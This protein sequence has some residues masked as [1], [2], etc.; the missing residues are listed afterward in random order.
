MPVKAFQQAAVSAGAATPATAFPWIPL[1]IHLTPFHVNY[2]VSRSGTGQARYRV[3]GTMDDVQDSSVSALA[4]TL[5]EMASV[6]GVTAFSR[7]VSAPWTAVRV[8]VAS[9]SASSNLSFRV[10]QAGT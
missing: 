4:Y 8:I 3:Q 1:D 6:Q 5:H 2:V 10:T 9:A 7:E